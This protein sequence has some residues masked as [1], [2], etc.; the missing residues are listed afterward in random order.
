VHGALDLA[1]AAAAKPKKI[2][3]LPSISYELARQDTPISRLFPLLSR[4]HVREALVVDA[5]SKLLGIVTQTDLLA[6]VGRVQL[7]LR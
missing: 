1:T 5:D 2:R 4:G 7:A 3:E 6:I